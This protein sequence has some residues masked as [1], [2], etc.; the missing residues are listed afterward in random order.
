MDLLSV[1]DPGADGLGALLETAAA[2]KGDQAA[3]AGRLSGKSVGLFFEKPSLRT[4][5]SSEV[6]ALKLGASPL[7]IKQD[8]IGLGTRESAAD[9]ARVL[10]RYFD[11]LALR[12]FS[13]SDLVT[14]AAH[15]EAPVVNLLS[16][17]EHPCQAIAD[18]LT[19]KESRPL[20]GAVLA[21]VGDGNNVCHSLILAG[22][23]LG[24]TVRVAAP[25]SHAP[26]PDVVAAARASAAPGADVVITEDPTEAVRGADA[27]YTDVWASMGQ[28]AEAAERKTIFSSYRVDGR[29]FSTAA[30][31]S[32]FLHCLPA[33]RGDEVTDDVM[34]HP[35]SRV[36]DQAENRLHAFAAVL[37]A[38]AG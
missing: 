7:V 37:I 23:A 21:Y 19:L 17:L 32:I 38:L 29:L 31:T 16:D 28:E 1:A 36:F 25:A 18:L 10:D 11:L 33:H 26:L 22:P 27:V 8:E 30:E 14:I 6:A 5:A 13:H 35:R 9:V 2:F 12:V 34:D 3:F 24:V 20:D 15:A 4:R